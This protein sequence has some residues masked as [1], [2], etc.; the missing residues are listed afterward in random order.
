MEKL[1]RL[2]KFYTVGG[3]PSLETLEQLRLEGFRS[4]INLGTY[5][6]SLGLSSSLEY[7]HQPIRELN[8]WD[9]A[10]AL[11]IFRELP[12]PRYVYSSSIHLAGCLVLIQIAIEEGMDGDTIAKKAH[13]LELD[14]D[15][16]SLNK[17]KSYVDQHHPVH[18]K[19]S[20][21]SL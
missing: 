5:H 16:V 7:V 18:E 21:G 13:D 20:H 11:Q 9:I 12:P 17:L 4:A 2:N 14:G 6:E 3:P 10:R 19:K 15:P 1:I 8:D